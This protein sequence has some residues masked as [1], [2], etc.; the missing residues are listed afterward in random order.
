[1]NVGES[2]L[3]AVVEIGEPGVIEAE[4]MQDRGVEVVE[5][6]H[7]LGRFDT[8]V[9]GCPVAHPLSHA[10]SSHPAG[11]AVR[12]VVAALG[13]LLKKLSLGERL[14]RQN[15]RGGVLAIFSGG[16]AGLLVATAHAHQHT[17]DRDN[18]KTC[19][20][21]RSP[22]AARTAYSANSSM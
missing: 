18:D 7:V 20:H 8:E 4:Q 15:E 6:P 3:E 5:G 14:A 16:L 2:P 12:I 19:S 13:P 1:V 22:F 21:D 9:I 10:S 11:E 17:H